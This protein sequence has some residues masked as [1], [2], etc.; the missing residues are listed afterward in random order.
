MANFF[1]SPFF[2]SKFFTDNAFF[3]EP[4][5]QTPFFDGIGGNGAIVITNPVVQSSTIEDAKKDGIAVKWD[6]TMRGTGDLTTVI[7]VII[8]GASPVAPKSVDFNQSDPSEMAIIMNSDFASGKTVTWA[9]DDSKS[10]KLEDVDNGTEAENQTYSV[11]NNV[12]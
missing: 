11:T 5:F 12:S 8:D 2:Q 6:R 10:V 3:R 4:F 7:S 9:Y 1:E